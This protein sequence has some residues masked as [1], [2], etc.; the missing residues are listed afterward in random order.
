MFYCQIQ[1]L[2][3]SEQLN[4]RYIR[5]YDY[6]GVITGKLTYFKIYLILVKS[7][8]SKGLPSRTILENSDMTFASYNGVVAPVTQSN[9][10]FFYPAVLL[11]KP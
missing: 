10:C 5:K 7:I 6:R 2:H 4:N 3:K 1:T 8:P 11:Q 9:F